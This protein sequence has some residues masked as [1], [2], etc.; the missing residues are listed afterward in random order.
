M[1]VNQ[2]GF[3]GTTFTAGLNFKFKDQFNRHKKTD[4][5][6]FFMPIQVANAKNFYFE[7][8]GLV[9]LKEDNQLGIFS[10]MMALAEASK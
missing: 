4:L 8:E 3:S 5:V 10:I 6:P 9:V 7:I 1:E 2:F